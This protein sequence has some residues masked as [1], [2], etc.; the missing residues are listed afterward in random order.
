MSGWTWTV[1]LVIVI[2]GA[3]WVTSCQKGTSSS[4]GQKGLVPFAEGLPTGAEWRQDFVFVD[5]DGDG[6]ADI[7]TAPP[8]KSKEPWPHIFLRRQNSWEPVSCPGI[9]N[10][11]FPPQEYIYGGVAVADFDGDG[12]LEIAIA[13]HETGIRIFSNQGKGLCGPW[14]EVQNLPQTMVKRRSRTIVAA[15]MNKDGRV[16]LVALAEA[17]DM[18]TGDNTAG[19]TIYWNEGG[20]WRTE[21]IEGSKG[22]FGDDIA[23]GEVNGDG[24]LDIAV[25]SLDDQRPQFVWLSDGN[26]KWQAANA[27]GF[28]ANIVAWSVQLVDLDND[29]KDELLLGVGG[30]PVYKNGGPRVYRWD[31]TRW[32]DLS[33]GLPQMS[34]VCGVTATDLDKDGR[35]EIVAAEM[36]TGMVQVYGQQPDGTWVERQNFQAVSIDKLRNYKVHAPLADTANQSLVAANYAGENDGKITAWVWR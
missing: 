5:M 32:H 21:T 6:V 14:Q 19:I 26:G 9:A 17:V 12:K 36:Y 7:V 18:N 4:S 31:G 30:A 35:K 23:I 34:W 11:G 29:G 24:A 27:E 16:D 2:G 15:D 22:L 13:M 8:R 3:G 25:G 10:N 33:Q 1:V 20:G 28:A